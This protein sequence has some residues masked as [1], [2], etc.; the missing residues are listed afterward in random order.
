MLRSLFNSASPDVSRRLL[1]DLTIILILTV[2]AMSAATLFTGVHLKREMAVTQIENAMGV[3]RQELRSLFD[4]TRQLL[5]LARGWGNTGELDISDPEDLNRRFIPALETIPHIEGLLIARADGS[6]YFLLRSKE[7]WLSRNR[8]SGEGKVEVLWQRWDGVG[9]EIERWNGRT[10]YDPRTRPWFRGAMAALEGD[11]VYLTK[12]YIFFTRKAPGLTAAV[13]YSTGEGAESDYVFAV[14]VLLSEVAEQVASFAVA[15]RGSAFLLSGD[16]ALVL[17]PIN[18]GSASHSEE[19]ASLF[20]PGRYPQ[21]DLLLDAAQHWQQGGK[22][23]GVPIRFVS[24]GVPWW[25]AFVQI[26][27]DSDVLWLGVLVPESDLLGILSRKG[28]F[29]IIVALAVLAAGILLAILLVGKYRR[30]LKNMPKTSID[31]TDAVNEIQA[32]IGAGESAALEFKSTMRKN[33]RT[34]KAGKEIELAWLKTVV[35]FLNTDGGI[36]LIGVSDQGEILGLEEDG[37][38]NE[39]KCRLHFK[40]LINQHIGLE[41]SQYIQLVLQPV[42]DKLIAAV[43]C[44]RSC[45]PVFLST[46]KEEDFYI[47]SG[48]A[49]VKLSVSKAL[50]YLQ[51]QRG[52]IKR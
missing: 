7:N 22:S 4:P 1:R 44:E 40:N 27:D 35:A 33:L 2:G 47:R 13:H 52:Q 26:Y 24:A 32:L 23:Q 20:A 11:K 5:L 3:A 39:D 45:K 50:K 41:F 42:Q 38:E 36:L 49:S 51:T 9:E 6:E 31:D 30:L 14:D 46:G 43:E 37:F 8:P 17:P 12:P 16:G 10:E 28:S 48:P 29:I 21:G 15:G 25:A 19:Y 18:D 34:G